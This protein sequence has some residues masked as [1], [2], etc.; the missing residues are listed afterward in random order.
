MAD[1]TSTEFSVKETMHFRADVVAT[2][3][4]KNS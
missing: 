3:A 1:L 2:Q 4:W